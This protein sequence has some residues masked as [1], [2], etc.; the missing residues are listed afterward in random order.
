M[1]RS[2]FR[3]LIRVSIGLLIVAIPM[4]AFFSTQTF[5]TAEYLVQAAPP[6]EST[7][8]PFTTEET[9]TSVAQTQTS[10]AMTVQAAGTQTAVAG[11]QTSIA[12]TQTAVAATQTAIAQPSTTAIFVDAFEPNNTIQ[13]AYT[14]AP[15]AAALTNITLWPTGDI[16]FF[17]FVGKAGSAYRVETSHLSAGLDTV[18]TVYDT[19][20]NEIASNDD[21]EPDNRASRV[22]FSAH[23]DG[24]FFARIVNI[25]PGD[26]ANLT[27][28]FQV[29][30]IQGTATPTAFPTGTRVPGADICEYNGDFDSACLIG[31]GQPYDMNFVPLHGE[32]P[33]NDFFRLWVKAGLYYTC[34]SFDLSS[35]NDTNMIIYDQNRNGLGGNDDKAPG[36]L[37]SLVS[38]PATYTGWL[39]ILVGPYAPPEYALAYLYTYS[40]RCDE[41]VP[42]PTPTARP[43]VP[44]P[45]SGGTSPP[46]PT[47]IIFPTFPPTPTPFTF[48]T[49]QPTPRP[50]IQ[51]IPLPTNTPVSIIQPTINLNLT[52]YFDRN[53]NFTPELTEGVEDVAVTIYDN[54][55][56]EL[57]AFGYTNETG[58][59]RF[60]TLAVSGPVRISI[61]FLQFNQVVTGDS[62]IFIRIA[63]MQPLPPGGS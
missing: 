14:T 53:G 39:F 46:T 12:R 44:P 7:P 20:G 51:V 1:N 25:N 28:R 24:F 63:P 10:F 4:L 3:R 42:T 38:V 30:Q 15:D 49:P 62:T 23:V 54:A 50:V 27:Y 32:G 21:F 61:P 5:P 2:G 29:Q 37:G 18:L 33:D 45:I 22:T 52:V 8:V 47:P 35:V 34:Q 19:Q 17:N 43:Y 41:T 56:A 16:D 59:I 13:T 6:L 48:V 9:Q 57:L 58:A 31:V 55:T 11:T 26:P 60:G 40:I 36:D